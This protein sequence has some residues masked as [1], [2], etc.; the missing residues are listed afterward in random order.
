MVQ[1]TNTL[2]KI[3]NTDR[4][5]ANIG[6]AMMCLADARRLAAEVTATKTK[7]A[8]DAADYLSRARNHYARAVECGATRSDLAE[9]VQMGAAVKAEVEVATARAAAKARKHQRALS[10]KGMN[11][12][13]AARF[14][15]ERLVEAGLAADV[16]EG[17]EILKG[18]VEPRTATVDALF[19]AWLALVP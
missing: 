19:T 15:A 3:S 11:V 2:N 1:S 6:L 14:V 16:G 18:E 5:A 17:V 9:V 10:M 8:Q 7:P 12:R 4:A 13:E